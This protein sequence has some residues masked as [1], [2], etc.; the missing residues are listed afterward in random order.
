MKRR[1]WSLSEA[2]AVLTKIRVAES[3]EQSVTLTEHECYVLV[4]TF[5]RLEYNARRKS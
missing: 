3:F 4:K 1:S 5:E 2:Q